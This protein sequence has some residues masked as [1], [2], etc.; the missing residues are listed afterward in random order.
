[1]EDWKNYVVNEKKRNV[2]LFPPENSTQKGKKNYYV[3][4]GDN[5]ILS[6]IKN[7]DPDSEYPIIPCCTNIK[8]KE[9]LYNDYD[10]IR[11]NSQDY[12]SKLEEE[13]IKI[14]TYLKTQKILSVKQHGNV[15]EDLNTFLKKIY[16]N[17]NFLRMG[18]YQNSTSSFLHCLM[19][20]SSH[21][22][23]LKILNP[24]EKNKNDN[25]I[26]IRK[27]Y[28]KESLVNKEKLIR[29]FRKNIFNFCYPEICLQENSTVDV[30]KIKEEVGNML[31]IFSSEKYIRILEEIFKVNIFVFKED[32]KDK[33]TILE[34]PNHIHYHIRNINHK[35]VNI[36]IYKHPTQNAYELIRPENT[37]G[38]KTEGFLFNEKVSK[39]LEKIINKSG[40]YVYDE[41]QLRKNEYSYTNWTLL[42]KNY[43]IYNQSINSTGKTYMITIKKNNDLI[44]LFVPPCAPLNAPYSTKTYNTTTENCFSIFGKNYTRG[45]QGIWYEINGY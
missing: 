6:F 4:P 10:K 36:L 29:I 34:K 32:D 30:E 44:S 12:F 21:L 42:L 9:F 26:E 24:E 7:P 28:I 3:C 1:M 25:I 23:S 17:N 43:Q 38:K 13:K 11:E 16:K 37:S 39:Q 22:K 41:T 27:T 19:L 18:V 14:G 5:S 35:L 20:G 45:S 2:L 8:S 40:Y 31:E 15:P 33:S